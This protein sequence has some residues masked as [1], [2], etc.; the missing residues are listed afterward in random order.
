MKKPWQSATKLTL[1]LTTL[2]ILTAPF[3]GVST[4]PEVYAGWTIILGFY[5]GQKTS[6]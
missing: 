2:G 6:A 1:L 4:P 3:V 5:F